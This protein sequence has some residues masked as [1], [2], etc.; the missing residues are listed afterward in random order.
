MSHENDDQQPRPRRE[1]PPIKVWVTDVE[2]AKVAELA[3]QAGLSLSAYLLAAGLKNPI[4][5]KLDFQAVSDIAKVNGD[6]G[7]VAGLLKL[8]LA[9]K[10]GQG[11]R[12]IDVEAMMMDFRALQTEMTFLMSRMHKQ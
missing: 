8:W 9:E 4:R 1:V 6:L 5:S 7:R 2:K 11:A 12:P 10:R 3:D